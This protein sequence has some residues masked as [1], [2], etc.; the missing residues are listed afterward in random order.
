MAHQPGV[1]L[2]RFPQEQVNPYGIR[3]N[4]RVPRPGISVNHLETHIPPQLIPKHQLPPD[5][6]KEASIFKRIAKVWGNV[7]GPGFKRLGADSHADLTAGDLAATTQQLRSATGEW[8]TE[9][10]IDIFNATLYGRVDWLKKIEREEGPKQ[11]HVRGAHGRTVLHLACLLLGSSPP[12]IPDDLHMPHYIYIDHKETVPSPEI[13]GTVLIDQPYRDIIDYLV[14]SPQ[15]RYL[16]NLAFEGAY[17][18]EVAAHIA[19]VKRDLNLLK[20]LVDHGADVSFPRAT[21]RFF[22]PEGSLYYGETVLAFAACTGDE[23]IVKYI[24]NDCGAD[25]SQIDSHGNTALHVLAWWGYYNTSDPEG[26]K[27]RLEE[28]EKSNE[29]GADP[30]PSTA[31]LGGVWNVIYNK[32]VELKVENPLHLLNY[33]RWTP[34]LVAVNQKHRHMVHAIIESTARVEWSYGP[35]RCVHYPLTF[36]DHPSTRAYLGTQQEEESTVKRTYT[37]L[38]RSLSKRSQEHTIKEPVK[39]IPKSM[40][41]P[42]GCA[43]ELAVRNEDIDLISAEPIFRMLLEAKWI[44]YAKDMYLAYFCWALLYAILFSVAIALLPTAPPEDSDNY[45]SRW[46]YFSDAA[47][48]AGHW[49]FFIELCLLVINI[50]RLI[51]GNILLFVIIVVCRAVGNFNGENFAVG[52]AAI[53]FWISLLHYTKGSRRLGP[54]VMIFYRMMSWDLWRFIIIW[55]VMFVGFTEAM[56]LQ[57]RPPGLAEW[58]HGQND[59]NYRNGSDYNSGLS[60]WREPTGA[61]LWMFRWSLS[62]AEF[63]DLRAA[64]DSRAAKFYWVLFTVFTVILLFN[65]LIAML[66]TTYAEIIDHADR[67]WH[68]EWAKIVMSIDDKLH[69]AIEPMGFRRKVDGEYY[70]AFNFRDDI[71]Q[72]PVSLVATNDL[73]DIGDRIR[74][75]AEKRTHKNRKLVGEL[76]WGKEL[77]PRHGRRGMDE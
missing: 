55:G 46:D 71:P 35:V 73:T 39:K 5:T 77:A 15:H 40:K 47:G 70:F 12:P 8:K 13:D 21:G 76:R 32:M 56:Y 44:L 18:G 2:Q 51:W 50:I 72:I 58:Q 75:S 53:F 28:D 34:L 29:D 64:L 38:S 1:P 3:V 41:E 11:L 69:T 17:A 7:L 43:L 26:M 23:D 57:M 62:Q 52:I 16:L 9:D 60:D 14:T 20:L 68:V 33:Q 59:E 61:L 31:T 63:D 4:K 22:S 27:Q 67:K 74:R 49:R 37:K 19:V 30:K 36:L 54:L 45:I 10:Q 6:A 25:P 48:T 24:L 65:V 42:S 66:N